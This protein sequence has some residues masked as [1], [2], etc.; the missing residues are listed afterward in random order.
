VTRV[1]IKY[2]CYNYK[3]FKTEKIFMNENGVIGGDPEE[4]KQALAQAGYGDSKENQNEGPVGDQTE[5]RAES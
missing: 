3:K 4:M 2:N 5:E 1:K